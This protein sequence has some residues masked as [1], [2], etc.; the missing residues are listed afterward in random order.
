MGEVEIMRYFPESQWQNA[1]CILAAE[2]VQAAVNCPG[3]DPASCVVDL[4]EYGSCYPTTSVGPATA[5]GL[6]G[7][8]DRCWS[9]A[10]AEDNTPFTPQEWAA[11]LDPVV[12]VWMA[13]VVYSIAGWRAWSTC[14]QCGCCDVRGEPI[15]HPRGP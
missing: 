4:P 2:M 7:I 3:V 10:L 12:N 1:A 13:S 11:R 15:P 14:A 9:P 5:S 6:Y 8:V